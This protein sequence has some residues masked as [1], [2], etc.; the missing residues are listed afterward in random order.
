MNCSVGGKDVPQARAM[1]TEA[2]LLRLH[3][4][5]HKR[6]EHRLDREVCEYMSLSAV[7]SPNWGTFDHCGLCIH[8][9]VHT[10]KAVQED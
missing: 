4:Q 9:L 2:A 8:A 6:R 7:D 10:P 3:P 1:E 5:L